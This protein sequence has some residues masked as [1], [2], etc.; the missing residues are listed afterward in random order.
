MVIYLKT[1]AVL[2]A[3]GQGRRMNNPIPKQYLLLKEK[4]VLYY[5]LKTLEE[6]ML[7][8][9]ILI[10]NANDIEY[11]KNEIIDRYQFQKVKKI[12]CGGKERYYSVYNGLNE[13]KE[14][15]YVWI[16]DGA[17]PFL[18]NQ[19]ILDTFQAVQQYR[20]CVIGMPV[21]DTIKIVNENKIIQE[22][23]PRET[24][25][26]VQTPQ[27]FEFSLIKKAYDK[28]IKEKKETLQITDDAMLIE[29]MTN[30]DVKLVQ[31]D[32]HNIKITT[33]ED[34]IIAETFLSNLSNLS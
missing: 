28:F 9:I 4:P 2:L 17:R 8:E 14:V 15:D 18:T 24:I 13:L 31:G 1:A 7:D 29:Q 22:T 20:A 33:P 34:L 3:A 16:H 32:Y 30:C 12:I 25:W 27:V 6:S 5:S 11:C 23:P 10:T 21:K 26:S 19:M